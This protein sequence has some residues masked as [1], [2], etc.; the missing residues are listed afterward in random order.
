[1]PILKEDE[2]ALINAYKNSLTRANKD[3]FVEKLDKFG[4]SGGAAKKNGEKSLHDLM[5]EA[6]RE[7][8]LAPV[9]K[10]KSLSIKKSLG[11][12]D[13]RNDSEIKK[14]Q[15]RIQLKRVVNGHFANV[16]PKRKMKKNL[17][18]VNEKSYEETQSLKKNSSVKEFQSEYSMKSE[19]KSMERASLHFDSDQEDQKTAALEKQSEMLLK[20]IRSKKTDYDYKKYM[21]FL[22]F[23]TNSN[24]SSTGQPNPD[25]SPRVDSHSYSHSPKST[26]SEVN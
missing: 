25:G 10:S 6:R 16:K 23:D 5:L 21:K 11:W 1:M 17:T 2:A 8:G 7:S 20:E 22:E 24:V 3:L 14:E 13:Q 26:T 18:I 15:D 12:A 9:T 4:K 19:K